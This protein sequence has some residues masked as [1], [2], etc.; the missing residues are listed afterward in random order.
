MRARGFLLIIAANLIGGST[1]LAQK[2]G[3]E[4]L[5]PGI[6]TFLRNVVA[7]VAMAI[8]IAARGGFRTRYDR[9]AWVRLG[10]VGVLAFAAPLWLGTLGLQWSS[11]GNASILIL[12]EP[13]AILVF[14]ALLLKERI[15]RHQ[16]LGVAF[17]IAGALFIVL[18]GTSGADLFAG[19]MLLGNSLLVLH[20]LLWGLYS[21]VMKPLAADH[22]AIELTFL[23][24]LLGML[25]LTPVALSEWPAFEAGPGLETAL[26]WVLG[27]GL[28]GS[29][30]GTMWW[31][32]SLKILRASTVAPFVLL[33]PLAGVLGDWLVRD[34]VPTRAAWIGTALIV[35]GLLFVLTVPRRPESAAA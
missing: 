15:E 35:A 14:S 34:E 12:L 24:M 19:G 13:G 2:Q 16:V 25:L 1:Y 5:P 21:P 7:L 33:Q 29:F 3:L 9:A 17:G 8:L 32:A 26:W 11:A 22:P 20:A 23:S 18:D 6:V 31:N 4:A 28:I 30:L 27:L 10:V